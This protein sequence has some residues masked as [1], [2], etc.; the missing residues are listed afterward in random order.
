MKK[1]RLL[2]VCFVSICLALSLSSC[3]VIEKARFTVTEE[4]WVALTKENNYTSESLVEYEGQVN[5]TLQK[6]TSDVIEIDGYVV[7]FIDDKQY[8]L[9]ETEYGWIAQDV[10]SLDFWNVCLLEG[11]NF[12]DYTYNEYKLAYISEPDEETGTY[13]ELYFVNGVLMK[14]AYVTPLEEFG[15]YYIYETYYKNIG[16]TMIDVPEYSFIDKRTL[17]TEEQW[18]KYI[19]VY[20]YSCDYYYDNYTAYDTQSSTEG[21]WCYNGTYYVEIEKELFKLVEGESGYVALK[22]DTFPGLKGPLLQGFSF[23]DVEYDEETAQYVTKKPTEDGLIYY[24]IFFKGELAAIDIVNTLNPEE[25][26]KF[27]FIYSIEQTELEVPEYTFQTN[28]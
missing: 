27:Y 17:I 12:E 18:N 7:L 11:K 16:S 4:E 13:E 20:N 23:D 10:T 1:I 8:G 15:T 26:N 9:T 3:V 14:R 2:L 28:E 21:A 6:Y 19:N 24:F 25:E 5:K 22:V